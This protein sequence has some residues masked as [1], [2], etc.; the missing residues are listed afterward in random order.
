MALVYF[1]KQVGTLP[2]TIAA[3]T[4]YCVRAGAG[5]DL[6]VSDSTG[7][8]AYKVNVP[9]PGGATDSV[10]YKQ[11][12]TTFGG[13]A[14]VL[15][16]DG[17]LTLLPATTAVTST[18]GLKALART[19][20]G[21]NFLSSLDVDGVWN[22]AGNHFTSS[23]VSSCAA[24][25]DVASN[26]PSFNVTGSMARPEYNGPGPKARP[27]AATSY[28]TRLARAAYES[29]A[30]TSSFAEQYFSNSAITIGNGLGVGG[31]FYNHV[32][33]IGDA[34]LQAAATMFVGLNSAT[35]KSTNNNPAAYTNC[36]GVG[37]DTTSSNLKLYYGGSTAQAAIDL[38]ASFPSRTR[39]TDVYQVMICASPKTSS[40]TVE[41]VRLNTGARFTRTLT[42]A[43]AGV[44]LPA[45][46]TLLRPHAWRSTNT[47]SSAV[48][49]ELGTISLE[50]FL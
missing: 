32:F 16:K 49:L 33:C 2:A 8:I 12:A 28:L 27:I 42:A 24:I 5:F 21:R 38:G 26:S 13:A 50:T 25:P 4:L 30:T 3:N 40:V 41:V 9:V 7:A 14:D 10:Q 36:I 39:V 17:D 20:A 6:Y 44:Q 43:T 18:A 22:A 29:Y 11:G 23:I 46:T 35:T 47:S 31:F 15:I 1:I 48:T 19:V 34:A 45:S 37:C